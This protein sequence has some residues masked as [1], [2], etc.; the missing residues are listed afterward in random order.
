LP[1]TRSANRARIVPSAS[2]HDAID[3]MLDA[4]VTHLVVMRPGG[5]TPEG[6]V[7]DIDLVTHL[8]P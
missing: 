7:S 3:A 2:V 5:H 8:A 4:K 1:V 6:V